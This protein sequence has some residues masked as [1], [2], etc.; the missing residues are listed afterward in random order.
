VDGKL[1]IHRCLIVNY[2]SL[3]RSNVEPMVTG[4]RHA[5]YAEVGSLEDGERVVREAIER[6]QIIRFPLPL[7]L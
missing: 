3:F 1:D 7:E 4:I 2:L 6:G 5:V